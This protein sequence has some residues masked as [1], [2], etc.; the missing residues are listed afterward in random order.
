MVFYAA[1][2]AVNA[3]LWETRRYEPATHADRRTT[4][5][6]SLPLRRCFSSYRSLSDVGFH[7]RYD[8]KFTLSEQAARALLETEFREVE[9]TVMQALGRA[10]PVW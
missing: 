10:A 8:E 2:H 1:V 4:I 6:S 3:Y 7:A 9:A 5:R